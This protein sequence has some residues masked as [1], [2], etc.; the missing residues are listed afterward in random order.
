MGVTLSGGSREASHPLSCVGC[1]FA[2]S[3]G[4]PGA[5]PAPRVRWAGSGRMTYPR[6]CRDGHGVKCLL[7]DPAAGLGDGTTVMVRE[8]TRRSWPGS[9]PRVGLWL[10]GGLVGGPDRELPWMARVPYRVSLPP[11]TASRSIGNREERSRAAQVVTGAAAAWHARAEPGAV[12][13]CRIA[14]RHRCEFSWRE[15]WREIGRG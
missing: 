10:V 15:S 11:S 4:P 9:T 8:A 12:R 6:I 3:R 1:A 2:P 13:R 7:T 5:S 14:R